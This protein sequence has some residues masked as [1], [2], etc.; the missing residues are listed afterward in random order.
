MKLLEQLQET[1]YICLT[2]YKIENLS[3]NT[4]QQTS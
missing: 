3:K 2:S 1:S 4:I